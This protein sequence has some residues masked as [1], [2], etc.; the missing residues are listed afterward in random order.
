MMLWREVKGL[1]GTAMI[2]VPGIIS[3]NTKR[4]LSKR[5]PE[6]V[7]RIVMGAISEVNY[8][9]IAPLDELVQKRL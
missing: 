9:S 8:G 5:S 7:A 3:E 4:A 1:P 2:Q 6:D